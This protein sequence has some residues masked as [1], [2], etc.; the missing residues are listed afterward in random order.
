[1]FPSYFCFPNYVSTLTFTHSDGSQVNIDQKFLQL[2]T[3]PAS[4]SVQNVDCVS[5]FLYSANQQPFLTSRDSFE[6]VFWHFGSIWIDRGLFF[7]IIFSW[8]VQ[9]KIWINHFCDHHLDNP[10]STKVFRTSKVVFETQF[11][12]LENVKRVLF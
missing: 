12:A 5:F 9:V 2:V 10:T 7:V 6:Q 8:P 3:T 11:W 4:N 1:M